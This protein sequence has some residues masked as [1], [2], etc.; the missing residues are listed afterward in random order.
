MK[1]T[2]YTGLW[3]TE[4]AWY[5]PSATH[6]I[7]LYGLEHGLGIHTF[8]PIWLCLSVKVLATWAK[9]LESSGYCIVINCPFTFCTTNGFGC[10]SGD[11]VAQWHVAM[12]NASV[13]QL[14]RF[15]QPPWVPSMAWTALHQNFWL[16]QVA[17][18][19]YQSN[20]YLQNNVK[21]TLE[22]KKFSNLLIIVWSQYSHLGWSLKFLKVDDY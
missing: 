13:H 12:H 6:Q 14:P 10:F 15:Y 8:K 11:I 4:F 21:L 3:E 2:S 19:V 5:S 9:F 22:N 20:S 7:C 1:V 18:T 17:K 16:I